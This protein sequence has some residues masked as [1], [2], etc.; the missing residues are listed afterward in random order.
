M[1]AMAAVFLPVALALAAGS[2]AAEAPRE[3]TR[4]DVEAWLEGF[5]P[6]ALSRDDI[7]GAAVAVVGNGEVIAA[8]GYGYADAG[9]GIRV[10]PARTLFRTGSVGKLFTWTAVMQQVEA[11]RLDLDRDV[12]DYLDFRVP[13][14]DGQ[15]VTLR[16]LMTHTPGF[17]EAV[18]NLATDKAEALRSPEE[19]LKAW[20]PARIFPPGK[21]P[22]YSN[23][24]ATLAGYIVERVTG[25][26]YDDYVDRRVFAPLGMTRSTTRQIP[27]AGLRADVS[28]GYLLGSGPA[29][30]FE[31]FG[32]APA[33]G[34]A[35]TVTDMARF[36]IAWLQRGEFKGARILKPETVRQTLATRLPVVPPLNAML[37]GFY[38]QGPEGRRVVGHDGDTQFFHSTLSLFVEDGIGVYVVVNS[39]GRDGAAGA[40]LTAFM[41]EFVDRYFPA[42]AAESSVSAEVAA[43]HARQMV[44][45]YES[46]RRQDSN[47]LSVLGFL[48]QT[49]VVLD[50]RGGLRVPAFLDA[51]GEPMK[52]R[53]VRPYVWHQV[54]G[55]ERLAARLRDGRIETFSVDSVSPFLVLQPAPWWKSTAIF[56]PLLIA[57]LAVLA[58]VPIAWAATTI[59]RRHYR[60]RPANA[61]PEWRAYRLTRV[62]ALGALVVL[63]GWTVLVS[64]LSGNLF[65]FSSALDP[66]ITILKVSTMAVCAGGTVVASWNLLRGWVRRG[67]TA[68]I[69][70]SLLALAFV[71]VLWLAVV[72]ELAGF[73]TDY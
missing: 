23:Y 30:P 19:F 28:Q 27:P 72:L 14:R 73:G 65:A 18:K 15:P 29:Q 43:A 49:R 70:S 55:K 53:E 61:G 40:L 17:E 52:W 33:G 56:L 12:N 54:G 47:F 8:R 31:R 60:L 7:A 66:W 68:K 50:E 63:A 32:V 38:E 48:G 9:R 34:A 25:D 41:N 71:I 6:H 46:S 16:N 13:L 39:S 44:G 35:T 45:T 58:A 24:G 62:A 21:V 4:A 59:L 11:G 5:F 64:Q 57:A 51:N 26:A 2:Q 3:L 22:A 36:M 67:W 1:R 37:L 69:G 20:T 42:V 10:D